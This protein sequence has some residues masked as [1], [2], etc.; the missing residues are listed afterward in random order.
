MD[1]LVQIMLAIGL[2]AITTFLLVG[3]VVGVVAMVKWLM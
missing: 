2:V 1:R 3:S